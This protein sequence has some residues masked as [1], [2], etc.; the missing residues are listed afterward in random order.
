LEECIADAL[1][2]RPR[3]LIFDLSGLTASDTTGLASIRGARAT[4][5]DTGAVLILE[6]APGD[7]LTDLGYGSGEEFFVR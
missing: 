6:S 2:E 4:V 3:H 7:L 1:A 5:A